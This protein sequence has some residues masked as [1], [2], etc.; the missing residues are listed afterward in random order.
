MPSTKRKLQILSAFAVL[1]LMA[2]AAGCRGFFVNPTLTSIAVGPGNV[3]VPVGS[4]QQMVATGTYDD[5]STKDL[6][7]A[8]NIIWTSSD[9]TLATVTNGGLVQG[10][11]AGTPTITAE[12]G[13]VSGQATIKV[14]LT[15]VTAI[16]ITPTS[17]T[18]ASG[19]GTATFTAAATISGQSQPVDITAQAVWSITNSGNFQLTQGETPETIMTLS[20]A[21]AGEV[22]T[23]TATY[24]SGTT[25]FTKTA[26]LT[27]Q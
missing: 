16:T 8:S 6:T 4:T 19:G 12:V 10:V 3:N 1:L 25:Q 5:N 15:N 21:T 2:A 9:E 20:G 22:E 14:T 11:G 24:T 23:V 7:G 17:N 13:A 26:Q 18:I 27:V